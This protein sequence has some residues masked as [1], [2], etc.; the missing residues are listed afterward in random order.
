MPTGGLTRRLLST[1]TV[2]L[3]LVDYPGK[4]AARPADARP[5]PIR[6]GPRGWRS[7]P[8][9]AAGP[10]CP[11]VAGGRRAASIPGRRK[12]PPP[13]SGSAALS[14]LPHRAAGPSGISGSCSPDAFSSTTASISERGPV[15]FPLGAAQAY[16]GRRGPA[17]MARHWPRATAPTEA[18][19][20]LLRAGRLRR[21]RSVLVDLLTA[22][23][24]GHEVVRR[25]GARNPQPHRR[26]RGAG[27]SDPLRALSFRAAWIAWRW[28]R[29]RPTT[30]TAD[31][32]NNMIGLL[33][34]MIGEP[35]VQ[36]NARQ[37]GLFAAASVR[38]T[39]QLPAQIPGRGAAVPARGA[40][41]ARPGQ[42]RARRSRF[43]RA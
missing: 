30:R 14:R 36:A 26:V 8:T 23:Q 16:E 2:D 11:G 27:R 13:C 9:R 31:Q 12:T 10:I 6:N 41:R 24:N 17:A 1:A 29:P 34:D 20:P 7:W 28:S 42:K 21:A 33:R 32:M 38:A 22:L 39:T 35:F 25:H 43:V 15:F 18:R 19:A 37:S 3:D 5:S 40:R 4:M